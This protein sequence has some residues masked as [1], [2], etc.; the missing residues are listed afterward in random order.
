MTN[1]TILTAAETDH[2][3]GI[4]ASIAL[5]V[6]CALV[7]GFN[8]KYVYNFVDGP[9]PFTA[10][11]A[12]SPGAHEFVT[13]HGTLVPTGWAQESTLRLLRGVVESK[14]TTAQ[15]LAMLVEG[16]LLIVKV[17]VDFAGQTVEG[18]LVPLPAA[19]QGGIGSGFKPY[20]WMIDAVTG[21]RWDFNLFVLAAALVFP[22][23]IMLL[24]SLIWQA[25]DVTRHRMIARLTSLG[26]PLDVVQQLDAEMR[27]AAAADRIGP[28]VVT[29]SAIVSLEPSLVIV[30]L[31]ELAGVG[32]KTT[33]GK[34]GDRHALM[35]WVCGRV[36]TESVNVELAH[37]RAV[38]DRIAVRRPRAIVNDVAGFGRRWGR[39]RA[40]CERDAALQ[41]TA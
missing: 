23:A 22:V 36:L 4:K 16:R 14:T 12:S 6:V 7:L 19:I 30:P 32:I 27:A 11:L 29:P 34:S 13:V 24:G 18:R 3:T 35:F 39:D 40:A 10:A 41:Q 38:L 8:W 17:P 1:S 26:S 20:P 31:R 21:Y 2:A 37:A 25:R 9:V 15:Y 5:V 28:V 33:S